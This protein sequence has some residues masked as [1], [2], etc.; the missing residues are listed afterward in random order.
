MST[1]TLKNLILTQINSVLKR[2]C[3]LIR[4]AFKR[5]KILTIKHIEN[6][7]LSP[8]LPLWE[9]NEQ[10]VNFS[11]IKVNSL[12]MPKIICKMLVIDGLSRIYSMLIKIL[13]HKNIG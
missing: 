1:T 3:L 11:L 8:R 9:R 5:P 7:H 10:E 12:K 13:T 2:K 6:S 4:L